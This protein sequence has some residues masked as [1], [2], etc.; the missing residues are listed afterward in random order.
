MAKNEIKKYERKAARMIGRWAG[1]QVKSHPH[2]HFPIIP[3][4]NNHYTLSTAGLPVLVLNIPI[5]TLFF[6]VPCPRQHHSQVLIPNQGQPR[7]NKPVNEGVYS[8]DGTKDIGEV[9]R[10]LI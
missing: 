8:R 5:I 6:V 1:V 4:T 7:P 9:V 3:I 10:E 2:Y